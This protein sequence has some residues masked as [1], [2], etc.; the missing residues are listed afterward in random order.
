MLLSKS[1][2]DNSS[3]LPS[4]KTKL[5]NNKQNSQYIEEKKLRLNH[6]TF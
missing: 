3:Y 1:M 2:N 6:D 4:E 5:M